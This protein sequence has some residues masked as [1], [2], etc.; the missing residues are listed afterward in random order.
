MLNVLGLVEIIKHIY[1]YAIVIC[2]IA[3]RTLIRGYKR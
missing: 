3:S 1:D 2:F